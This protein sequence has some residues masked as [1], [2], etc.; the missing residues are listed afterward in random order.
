MLIAEL[1]SYKEQVKVLKEGQNVETDLSAEQVFWS[2]NSV[3]S[4][5]P[6]LSIR[7]TQVEV[8]KELPKVSMVNTSLKNL[9]HHLA[10]FDVVVK[11]RTT[12][13]SITKGTCSKHMIGDRSQLT[14][15]VN[16]FLGTVK[17]GNDYVEK[18][19]GYG[20][21]KIMNVAISRVYFL[22]GLGHNL[23]F[24][25]Q[26]YDSDLEVAFR[27]H[28]CFIRNLE[29]V[30]LLIGSRGN[31]LYTLSSGDMMASFPIC[32]LSKASKTKSWLWHRR[33]SHM[34]FYAINY[35]A[36]QGLV[37]RLPKLK[38]KKDH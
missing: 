3:N 34:N 16:K 7:S 37:R 17:L 2:Q 18:I 25:R 1:E 30:D 8:P 21:Y 22:E 11:E 32:L 23:F 6:N 14:N 15:F 20:D 10:S 29:G 33:L 31:N 38:F 19:M 9:K 24:V 36:R 28:T 26:F 13:I 4:E 12:A 27:Q 35:L 5:E